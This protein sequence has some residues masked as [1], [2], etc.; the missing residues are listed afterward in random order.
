MTPNKK[1]FDEKQSV[2]ELVRW[3]NA[4]KQPM[5]AYLVMKQNQLAAF[6]KAIVKGT[7][8]LTAFGVVVAYGTGSEPPPGFESK[9]LESIQ[10]TA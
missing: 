9:V 3:T 8:D 7:I 10:A 6:R 4:L 5:F 1:I 2:L